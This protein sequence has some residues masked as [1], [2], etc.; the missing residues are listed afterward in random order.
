MAQAAGVVQCA[1]CSV[2]VGGR[3]LRF[4]F[5]LH[6]AMCVIGDV[7]YVALRGNVG[8]GRCGGLDEGDVAVDA[9]TWGR[10]KV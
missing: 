6:S 10:S 5:L 3:G 2:E 1:E 7:C 4:T 9:D 8:V